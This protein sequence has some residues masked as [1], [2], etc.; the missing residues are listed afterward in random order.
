MNGLRPVSG[1][2]NS[3]KSYVNAYFYTTK[4]L[5]TQ[6]DMNMTCYLVQF[7]LVFC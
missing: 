3:S 4:A 1:D 6:L 5:A 7:S 2:V